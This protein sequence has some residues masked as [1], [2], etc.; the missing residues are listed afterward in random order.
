MDRA[1]AAIRSE[2]EESEVDHMQ[3]DQDSSGDVCPN[4]LDSGLR[5]IGRGKKRRWPQIAEK[6]DSI[7]PKKRSSI[8]RDTG[9]REKETPGLSHDNTAQENGQEVERSEFDSFED[10]SW[11]S[12][13]MAHRYTSEHR[14]RKGEISTVSKPTAIGVSATAGEETEH[15]ERSPGNGAVGGRRGGSLWGKRRQAGEKME[16][17]TAVARGGGSQKGSQMKTS[18]PTGHMK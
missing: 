13:E 11:S 7:I 10:T 6:K 12:T 4:T 17:A 14:A 3:T 8:E 2:E 15:T 1:G 5:K 9:K 16:C 18:S